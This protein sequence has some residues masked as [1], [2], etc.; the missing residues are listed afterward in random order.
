MK[1]SMFSGIGARVIAGFVA[2]TAMMV[3]LT[4]FGIFQ[5]R[6]ID[7]SLTTVNEINSVKQRYAIN[8]RGS[9]HD[10][11]ISLRDVVL[12]DG[13]DTLRDNLGTIE[14]LTAQYA[15]SAAP[16]DAMFADSAGTSVEERAILA[17][18]KATEA[19]TMPLI[20]AIVAQ[21]ARGDVAG[22]HALL[23]AEARPAFV[24]WLARINQLIDLEER[25]NQLVTADARRI[26]ASFQILM[27]GLCTAALL[28]G[29]G[30]A[31]WNMA[32][33][34]LLRPLVA[35]MLDLANGKLD[36]ELPSVRRNDEIAD[37]IQTVK[38]FKDGLIRSRDLERAATASRADVE[39]QRIAAMHAMADA[40]QSTVGDALNRVTSAAVHMR[41]AAQDLTALAGET[42]RQSSDAAG[43]AQDAASNVTT[44]ASAAEELGSSVQEI[45]RQVEGSSSLA[46]MA[47]AEAE[48]AAA[49]V[50]DLKVAAA[51][52]TDVI[53]MIS[54]IAGQ[55]NLLALNATI[56]AARAGEAGRGFAVVAAEVKELASQTARATEEI[57]TQINRIQATTGQA[58]GAIGAIMAR[59][60][61]INGFASSVAEAV[62]EQGAA[63]QEIAR[64]VAMAA[65]GTNQVTA[66]I[67]GVAGIAEKSGMAA[68]D[69]LSSAADLSEQSAYLGREVSR[70]LDTIRAA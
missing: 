59:I 65:G 23:L 57:T 62:E 51:R 18:I 49:Q 6:S 28:V 30:F 1:R 10:R 13:P 14:R 15:A 46:Q 56:E 53:G 17:S 69:V 41:G 67:A 43:A 47:V 63:T 42:A 16:L 5:V 19:R 61:E 3:A 60:N 55:T 26:A 32:S 2:I 54:A 4:T 21:K 8:F 52:I 64:N 29:L 35:R 70:F 58:V 20:T 25:K 39:S 24:E 45:A 38:V 27:L 33:I 50:G 7:Q 66:T 37:I 9:V 34:R 44:V 40:F 48:Q 12:M 11:A 68:S 36:V 31:A 22:A